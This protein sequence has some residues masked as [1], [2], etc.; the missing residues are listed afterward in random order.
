MLRRRHH[1]HPRR[2]KA[3]DVTRL[4][5]RVPIELRQPARVELECG[6]GHRTVDVDGKD[7]N[8]A[9]LL[10][11]LQPIEHFLDPAGGKRRNDHFSTALDC[12]DDDSF[13]PGAAIVGFVHPIPVG[14]L[15]EQHVGGFDG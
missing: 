8:A 4:A 5:L 15:D 10:E 12:V 1:R 14:R 13:E 9:A 3:V 7:G 11:V 6:C 2:V